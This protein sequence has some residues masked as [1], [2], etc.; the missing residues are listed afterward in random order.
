MTDSRAK[1]IQGKDEFEKRA[2][3][4]T[5]LGRR[6]RALQRVRERERET[7]A[8]GKEVAGDELTDLTSSLLF[9]FIFFCLNVDGRTILK[10]CVVVE[11]VTRSSSGGS[12][13]Y[14][15][16]LLN[17]S[18]HLPPSYTSL[19]LFLSHTHT[20]LLAPSLALSHGLCPVILNST[21]CGLE[22]RIL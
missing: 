1:L 22:N 6:A 20:D 11:V 7:L 15:L 4:R 21:R 14:A 5:Q 10:F 19:S 8:P 18:C 9:Y 17:E 16:Q 3:A 2:R 12:S 13:S